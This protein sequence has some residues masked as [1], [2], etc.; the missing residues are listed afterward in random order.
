MDYSISIDSHIGPWGY[1][2]NYIR[3]QMSGLKTNLSMCVFRP[4][5]AR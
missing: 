3:S 5:V 2:K 1:S 4:S